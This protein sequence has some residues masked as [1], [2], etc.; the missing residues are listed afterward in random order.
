MNV[1][2][3]Q[4]RNYIDVFYSTLETTAKEFIP[5][6]I[7]NKLFHLS[8]LPAKITGYVSTQFGVGI[9]Y[10]PAE[11][12]TV[13]VL[14]GSA[15]VEDLFIGAPARLKNLQPVLCIDGA[16]TGIYR[17]GLSGSFPFRLNNQNAN[18]FIGEVRFEIGSWRRDVHYAEIFGDRSADNWSSEK[19]VTRAKNEV[20]TAL[21]EL[22]R[23]EAKG[24]SINEYI[25]KF[26]SKTVLLLGDYHQD[27]LR[28]LGSIQETLV[29]LGYEPILLKDIPDH[30]H[31]DLSQKVVAFGAISRFVIVD[32]SSSSGHLAEVPLCKQNGWVTVLLRAGGQSGSWMTAGVSHLSNVILEKSYDL[33]AP[34][35][36]VQE[37]VTWAESKLDELQRQFEST[38]PWRGNFPVK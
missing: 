22:R 37:A 34:Q 21:V 27:G 13:D 33:A 15:R 35:I 2:D 6:D 1:T 29:H 38:Y 26:K 11:K 14:L 31:H 19:A 3:E 23:A 32:D 12:T 18:V 9:E 4:L 10:Q 24:I 20:I 36:A 5:S 30:P 7:R 17:L 25:E 8:L 16:K 28:R